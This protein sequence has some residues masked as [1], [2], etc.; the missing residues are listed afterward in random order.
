VLERRISATIGEYLPEDEPPLRDHREREHGPAL[1]QRGGR[2]Y[3]P[4]RSHGRRG[5]KKRSGAT[6]NP[7]VNQVVALAEVFGVHP[8]Y[9]LDG[10][11]KPPILDREAMAI[12]QDETISAI[13]HKILHLPGRERGMTLGIIR[14]FVD[15]Q[16]AG[17]DR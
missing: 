6:P 9:F 17:D 3:E 10:G 7:S 5:G 11:S 15:M 1:H 4:G 14:Q 16:E 2:P 13:A 12:L 8:S